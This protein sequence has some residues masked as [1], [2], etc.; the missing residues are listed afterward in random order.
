MCTCIHVQPLHARV[1]IGCEAPHEHALCKAMPA[2]LQHIVEGAFC[3]VF[4]WC[5]QV[6][7]QPH[8]LVVA[9]IIGACAK[10]NLEAAYEDMKVG[11]LCCW[12]AGRT[13][14]THADASRAC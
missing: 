4:A 12:S 3:V 2:L 8:P 14:P 10:G 9:R 5:K 1:C 6:C 7:D 13:Q 11:T